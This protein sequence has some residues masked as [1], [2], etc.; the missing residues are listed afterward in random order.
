M[1]PRDF[2]TQLMLRLY[3]SVTTIVRPLVSEE[4]QVTGIQNLEGRIDSGQG[5][6]WLGKHDSRMDALNL[7]PL[8]FSFPGHPSLRGVS[9]TE[10]IKIPSHPLLSK[11]LSSALSWVMRKTL[12][13]EVHRVSEMGYLPTSEVQRLRT[14]NG[15]I[16]HQL[17]Q[18]YQQG[19]QVVIM[20]EGTTKTDGHIAVIRDG[21]Y[22]LC[23]PNIWCVPFGNTY[24]SMSAR[25]SIF[26]RSRDLVFINF[27]IPFHY[28]PIA[29]QDEES[30]IQ[31]RVRDKTQF[32]RQIQDAF[33]DLNTITAGQLAGEYLMSLAQ[34]GERKWSRQ[35]MEHIISRRV[36]ALRQVEGIIIDRVLLDPLT[37]ERRIYYLYESLQEK[38]YITENGE[39]APER[40]LFT[41]AN[42]HVYKHQNPLRYMAN[43]LIGIAK[44]RPAIAQALQDTRT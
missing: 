5:A 12:F 15:A 13:H 43:R 2:Y 4:V 20:P 9:R 23:Q 26:G 31:Y 38:G 16:L 42:V 24:D 41:P 7:P 44:E 10:Y 33:M 19:T 34:Q 17:Q 6:L 32:S 40:V 3:A 25:K 37:C 18:L 22:D 27:G 35:D 14:E 36:E 1:F 28:Q 21:A 8:W 11:H 30:D 29:R 39:I